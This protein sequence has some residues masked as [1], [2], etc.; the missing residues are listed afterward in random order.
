MNTILCGLFEMRKILNKFSS[1][2]SNLSLKKYNLTVY[3]KQMFIRTSCKSYENCGRDNKECMV[4][5]R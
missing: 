3:S 5:I 4:Y 1:C 2:A